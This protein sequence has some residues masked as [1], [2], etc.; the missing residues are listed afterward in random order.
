VP[1]DSPP[2]ARERVLF[3]NQFVPPDPAPTARLLGEVTEE[4]DR[5]G[6]TTELVGDAVDYRG[7]KTL[8][9]SRALREAISLLRLLFRAFAA[10]RADAI[11]VLTSPPMVPVIAALARIRHRRAKLIHWAM[12]L[13]PDVAVALGEVSEGSLLHRLT[14]ALMARVYRTCDLVIVLDREMAARV[15]PGAKRIEIEPPWPPKPTLFTLLGSGGGGDKATENPAFTWLYSGNLGR[16]HEWRTLLE[17][18][19]RLEAEGLAVD[20]VFQ[21]GGAERAPAEAAAAALGLRRCQ[22]RDY[23]P[24]SGLMT[25]L[26]SADALV[27]TQRPET[28]GCL[29]PSKLALAVRVGRPVLWVGSRDGSVA[30]WLQDQGHFACA[31][32]DAEALAREIARLASGPRPTLADPAEIFDRITCARKEGIDRVAGWIAEQGRA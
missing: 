29:W 27:A 1:G 19:A 4:L 2:G 3:L 18:Q 13:Y 31:P 28:A 14:A 32:G 12:D 9:G 17:A 30:R 26:F 20:L 25:S 22:W 8:L 6:F 10:P 5:R 11:V 21:G 24:E 7:G 16:A 23:A 15:G